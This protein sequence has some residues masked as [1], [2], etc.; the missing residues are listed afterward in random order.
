MKQDTRSDVPDFLEFNWNNLGSDF[1]TVISLP[2]RD[3]NFATDIL[4]SL[5]KYFHVL[6]CARAQLSRGA[7]TWTMVDTYHSAMLG[8]RGL[9]ALYGIL[10]YTVQGR[11]VL[12]DFRPELGDADYRSKFSKMYKRIDDPIRVLRPKKLLLEQRDAWGLIVRLVNITKNAESQDEELM[13]QIADI[14]ETT[15]S[16]LRNK[17]LYD[18]VYWEWSNDFSKRKMNPG[19]IDTRLMEGSEIVQSLISSAS[20]IFD[21]IVKYAGSLIKHIGLD[22]HYL[23]DS[24]VLFQNDNLLKVLNRAGFSGDSNS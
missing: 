13:K 19:E 20:I 9:I 18:S 23:P 11:T 10:C 2:G 5:T 22:S 1:E 17:V 3:F 16:S 24:Y 8:A 7:A 4:I 14:A 15:L 12:V 21:V 6:E